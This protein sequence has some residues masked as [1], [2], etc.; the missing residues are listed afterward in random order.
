MTNPL[1]AVDIGNARM[2]I[3]VFGSAFA[4][5]LPEPM[6]TLALTG[7]DPSLDDLASW[8]NELAD[9]KLPWYLASVNRPG[10]ARLIEWL[11]EHRPDD[12]VTLLS[13]GDLPLI[14]RLERPDMVG[15][16]RLVDAVAVNRVRETG[17]AAVIV[18]VGTAIT[19]DLISADGVFL[20]GSI[21]PGLAMAA[22]ALNEF[23]DLLPLVDVSDLTEPPPALGTTTESAMQSGLFWGA[24]GAI[25]QLIDQLGREAS[26][27]TQV[28]LTGGAGATVAQLLASD[29]QYIAHLT[30]AGIALTISGE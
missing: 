28:F 12:T 2:K 4:D 14:V 3:G 22:R 13:A 10:A 20:G 6:Q 15:I 16:D 26:H 8:L 24:V 7:D 25:C 17:R 23:T 27:P 5:A 11:R 1:I 30:L 29:A 9:Q 18:D 21:L 19:V